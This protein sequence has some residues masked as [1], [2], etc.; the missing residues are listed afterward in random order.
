MEGARRVP[1]QGR[2]EGPRPAGSRQEWCR[3]SHRPRATDRSISP[4]VTTITASGHGSAST[5]MAAAPALSRPT[6]CGASLRAGPRRPGRRARRP[7]VV[8][9][10]PGRPPTSAGR[11]APDPRRRNASSRYPCASA[12]TSASPCAVR[13]QAGPPSWTVCTT[14]T[15]EGRRCTWGVVVGCLVLGGIRSACGRGFW[16]STDAWARERA[17]VEPEW[18]DRG[19]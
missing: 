16:P 3:V 8:L 2:V 6:R 17:L 9:P 4:V 12:A 18:S 15:L 5:A 13:G 14:T 7:T 10:V 19:R 1:G 11:T